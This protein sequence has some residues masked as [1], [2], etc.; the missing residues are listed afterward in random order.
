MC[1]AWCTQCTQV[2]DNFR[3]C[4]GG[5]SWS[6]NLWHRNLLVGTWRSLWTNQDH[7]VQGTESFYSAPYFPDSLIFF[8]SF[9]IFFG[10][11]CRNMSKLLS[12][13]KSFWFEF[14]KKVEICRDV[15]HGFHGLPWSPT[16]SH[17]LPRSPTVS[18]GL[19]V[20]VPARC[21]THRWASS[22]LHILWIGIQWVS[23]GMEVVSCISPIQMR[24][25][26]IQCRLSWQCS[27]KWWNLQM[28][29]T[30]M[31]SPSCWERA[32]VETNSVRTKRKDGKARER[33]GKGTGLWPWRF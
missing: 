9:C 24:A 13:E 10:A 25:R 18:H 27:K 4:V 5:G 28:H 7:L 31:A 22:L 3:R 32:P 19:P 15:L 21:Q 29:R 17:G 20:C 1:C 6:D 2:R 23:H 33:H 26:F 30:V 8:V 14:K 12:S 11:F 16:V